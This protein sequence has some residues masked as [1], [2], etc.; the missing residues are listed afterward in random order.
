[1]ILVILLLC[2]NAALSCSGFAPPA[3]AVSLHGNDLPWL[4]VHEM[5]EGE[6]EAAAEEEE[7]QEE[8]G[9]GAADELCARTPAHNT[10][11]IPHNVYS[12]MPCTHA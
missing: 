4:A 7:G 8:A 11:C 12:P 5:A 9:A 3:R 1:M 10:Q 6:G 2:H